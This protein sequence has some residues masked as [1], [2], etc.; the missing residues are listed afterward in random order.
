MSAWK[1]GARRLRRSRLGVYWGAGQ[2]CKTADSVEAF[3]STLEDSYEIESTALKEFSCTW[4]VIQFLAALPA[5]A[6]T[7]PFTFTVDWFGSSV[8]VRITV[9]TYTDQARA[10]SRVGNVTLSNT[11][12]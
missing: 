10:S 5:A 3:L 7:T 8:K 4:V 1:P 9:L 12:H 2:G 6:V 11:A